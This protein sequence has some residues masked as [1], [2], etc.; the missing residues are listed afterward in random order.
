MFIS[1]A[2]SANSTFETKSWCG[3]AS[4]LVINTQ[5]LSEMDW[6]PK[7]VGTRKNI[8]SKES[9]FLIHNLK[10]A[11]TMFLMIFIMVRSQFKDK[12]R[13]LHVSSSA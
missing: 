3:M 5:K 7:S 12:V 11:N 4:M 2:N 1:G 13:I 6:I 8:M 10:I 9:E